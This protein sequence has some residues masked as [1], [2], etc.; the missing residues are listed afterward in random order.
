MIAGTY[1]RASRLAPKSYSRFC[2]DRIYR[3]LNRAE[4]VDALGS[5]ALS[6][7]E[8]FEPCSRYSKSTAL[9]IDTNVLLQLPKIKEHDA[10]LDFISSIHEGP[11]VIPGQAV[12]ELWNNHLSVSKSSRDGLADSFSKFKAS[13]KNIVDVANLTEEFGSVLDKFADEHANIFSARWLETLAADLSAFQKLATSRFVERTRFLPVAE[14]RHITKTP[15]GFKDD[16]HGDFFIWADGLYSLMISLYRRPRVDHLVV[17][18]GEK[19]SDWMSG[20]C[21]HPLLSAEV[22]AIFGASMEICDLKSFA[23]WIRNRA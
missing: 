1:A 22:R 7:S 12:Q 4:T 5:T 8:S 18:S 11:V 2:E 9:L 17:L 16:G 23:Y 10:V 21:P 15:P 14:V 20:D 3:V 6:L 19:K 13:A